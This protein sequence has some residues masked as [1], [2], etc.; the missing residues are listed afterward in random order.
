MDNVEQRVFRV[1]SQVFGV[2]LGEV[3]GTSSRETVRG[4]DSLN[5]VNL[6][7]AVEDEFGIT[8]SVD[9]AALLVSVPE[10]VRLVRSRDVT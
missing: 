3:N 9:E 6:M 8:V 2:P 7:M 4:W 5:A 10:I 1:V